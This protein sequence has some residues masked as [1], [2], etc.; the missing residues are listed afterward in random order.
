MLLKFDR[1]YNNS[2]AIFNLS[3]GDLDFLVNTQHLVNAIYR[4][5]EILYILTYTHRG[6]C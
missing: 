1:K 6:K 3:T 2:T 5:T 4:D